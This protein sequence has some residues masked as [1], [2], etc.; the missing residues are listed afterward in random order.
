MQTFYGDLIHLIRNCVGAIPSKPIR[1][2]THDKVRAQVVG[3][4]VEFENVALAIANV[5][6]ATRF[7]EKTNRL[8]QI[9]QPP[10]AFLLL[11]G[12]SRRIALPADSD[13]L[14]RVFRFDLAQDSEM[15]SPTIPI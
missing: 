13:D 8:P 15:I 1:L 9:V 6:A 7:A 11:D 14:A 2:H 3:Q 4:A 5:D 12:N 10:Q